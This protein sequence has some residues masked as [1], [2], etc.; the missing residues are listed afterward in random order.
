MT[1]K[2]RIC[3]A[4]ICLI[5]CAFALSA[6]GEGEHI[7]D[8]GEWKTAKQATCTENG[9]NERFC[10]CG[11]KQTQTVEAT[12]HTIV[13]ESAVVGT[14][15]TDGKTEGQHCSKCNAVLKESTVITATG[16]QY[17]E[18][19]ITVEASC[20]RTGTKTYTCT[21]DGCGH[22]YTEDYSLPTYTATELYDMSVK[23]VGEIVT[24]DKK[25]TEMSLGTGFVIS[26]DGRIV[27]N[28]HV[29]DG[30]YSA[31]ITING[32][33]YLI[34]SILAYDKDIDLA[35]LKV[36]ATGMTA[37]TV[38]KKP[39]KVG[40]TVYAIGSSRGMT[41]T[42][43]QGIVTYADR[44]VDGVSHVQHDA[45]ITHGNSGGPLIN[46]YGEVVGINTW[47][48]S[49]SQN[50]NFAVFAGEL[51]NLK[52]GTALTFAEFY[53]K[54]CD[55][56][57]RLKNYII[58]NGEYDTQ[59][60]NYYVKIGEEYSSDRTYL[61]TMWAYYYPEDDEIT[62]DLALDSDKYGYYV[63]FCIDKAISGRYF[64]QY[65][66]DN[67]NEMSG[68]LV[69][70]TFTHNTLL[71]YSSNNITNATLR[72]DVRELASTMISYICSEMT[73]VFKSINVTPRDLGFNSYS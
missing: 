44:V 39:V 27:T 38:C 66:D 53:M 65:F 2:K 1:M 49:D 68:T 15:T 33:K 54:E 67:D 50:L 69:A 6:C 55:A 13:V 52:Y 59:Y 48:I 7:H 28:Y 9:T 43:S 24:Y 40:E 72:E 21:A 20:V 29:I 51:D 64:W 16:H 37:A 61:F 31:D 60:R 46:V 12:G 17:G 41:N 73:S 8:Y 30:A 23:Y 45:S 62:L 19:V 56:F 47:G 10:G 18:A 3:L 22:S 35:V 63:Y 4:L 34:T 70:N 32:K 42:Y 25:G 5:A 57:E 14:C 11:E 36:S 26:A 58:Q 71:G